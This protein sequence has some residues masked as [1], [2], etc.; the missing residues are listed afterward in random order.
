MS[1]ARFTPP[2]SGTAENG[3]GLPVNRATAAEASTSPQPNVELHV[4]AGIPPS[5]LRAGAW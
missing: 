5:I 3:A 4:R 2:R 1:F